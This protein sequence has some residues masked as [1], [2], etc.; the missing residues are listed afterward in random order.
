MRQP[1]VVAAALASLATALAGAAVAVA[2]PSDVLVTT[3][4][5]VTPFSQNKQN[6]PAVAIDAHAKVGA[7]EHRGD[8]RHGGRRRR[9]AGEIDQPVVFGE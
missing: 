9:A 6:E 5:P 7:G 3:G 8:R 1:R 2:A 4:S